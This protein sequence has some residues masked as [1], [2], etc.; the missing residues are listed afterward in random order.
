MRYNLFNRKVGVFVTLIAPIMADMPYSP[1]R[2]LSS[3]R[4]E[5]DLIYVFQPPT[6]TSPKSQLLALNTTGTI[7]SADIPYT[8][9]SNPLPF[10]DDESYKAFT[11]AIDAQGTI[12]VYS[13]KCQDGAR[14]STLWTFSPESGTNL[15]DG[16]WTQ[17]NLTGEGSIGDGIIQGANFLASGI[18]FSS[19]TN[20]SSDMYI[21]GGMCPSK[22]SSSVDNW[23]ESANYSNVMLTI[24]GASS[25]STDTYRLGKSASRGPPIPE[26]GFTI[27][28]L[29]PTFSRSPGSDQ[30]QN[31]HQNFVLLG[32]HTQDAFINMSQVALFSLP[33]QT[34][35]FLPVDSPYDT[36]KTDLTR[37]ISSVEPRS[38]HTAV[39][40]PDGRQLIIFGGWVGDVRTM[41]NPQLAVLQL[42]D[43]YGGTGDWRWSIPVSAGI[44]PE[45]GVGI[46]GHGAVMLPGSVMMIVGGYLIPNSNNAKWKRGNPSLNP[47]TYFFNTTS[48]SWIPS[49][50]HPIS[51]SGTQPPS[52]SANT[53]KKTALEAGLTLGILALFI[54]IL[55][56]F[57][58]ARRLKRRREVRENNLRNLAAGAHRTSTTGLPLSGPGPEMTV[59]EW[60]GQRNRI[61]T[62]AYPWATGPSGGVGERASWREGDTEAERTGLLFEVP[63]PTRGLRRSLHSRGTYQ[64]AP[65]FDDGRRSHGSGNIQTID[66][67]DEYE[68]DDSERE[69]SR[70]PETFQPKNANILE[71]AP[72][73]DPFS[74]PEESSRTPSPSSPQSPTHAREI[75]VQNWV[76]DWAVAGALMQ[77]QAGR[78][79]PDKADRTSSTLS[80]KSTR[81][82]ISSHSNPQAGGSVGRSMSQ[83]SAVLFSSRPLSSTS[84][85]TPPLEKDNDSHL[86]QRYRHKHRRSQSLTL[87]PNS[88]R[89]D[90]S[91]HFTAAGASVPPLQLESEALLGGHHGPGDRVPWRTQRRARGWMGSV[92]RAFIGADRNTPGSPTHGEFSAASSPT[93]HHH[94]ED[95]APRRAAST[96]AMLWTKRQ[97]ARDWDVEDAPDKRLRSDAVAREADDEE[98]DIESAVERRVVQV[99]FTVPKEKL[100]VVNGGPDGD[101]ESFVSAEITEAEKVTGTE[102]DDPGPCKGK[103]KEEEKKG[104]EKDSG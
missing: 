100:R 104:K 56:Y 58:Y 7:N 87:S 17:K 66:E 80:E 61:S 69:H 97:G 27:T 96:G 11:P 5:S 86:P 19:R 103:A 18:A 40:T 32:G 30:T 83:R 25:P 6:D 53:A 88:Q 78:I 73:L 59:A 55:F 12:M 41:A 38:G 63:S 46:F 20:K 2:M 8:I 9:I 99:M 31:R 101:G 91:D 98:W 82:T 81:S 14:G 89:V 21:F 26:A 71:S 85:T 10:L 95:V 1:T 45:D 74:N 72:I 4:N 65:R 76:S 68:E 102:A 35:S 43:G 48:S 39:L 79:S 29:E 60:M 51:T 37:D 34:W 67:R 3:P 24:E 90:A 42:G 50:T 22:I 93:K 92:R 94:S 64:L 77:Q 49:F 33:E 84:T 54:L 75:E 23:T 13:G 44:G 62:S 47:T 57:W 36:A 28:P 70:K 15:V 52:G 16:A